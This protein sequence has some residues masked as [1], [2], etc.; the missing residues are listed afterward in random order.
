MFSHRK[1]SSNYFFFY[2]LYAQESHTKLA[3]L[4][5]V[6]V[7]NLPNVLKEWWEWDS[8]VTENSQREYQGI[9]ATDIYGRTPL[10]L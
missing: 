8:Y 3:V 4:H 2:S 10:L 5:V 6:V 9:E 7:R 1:E